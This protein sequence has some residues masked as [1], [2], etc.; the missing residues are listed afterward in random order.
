M[1]KTKVKTLPTRRRTRRRRIRTSDESIIN[2]PS[3]PPQHMIIQ[4]EVLLLVQDLVLQQLLVEGLVSSVDE[5][6]LVVPDDPVDRVPLYHEV[7]G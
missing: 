1:N 6:P 5:L 3:I 7:E 2:R 4:V